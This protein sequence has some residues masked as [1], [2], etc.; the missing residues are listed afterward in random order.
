MANFKKGRKS[1]AQLKSNDSRDKMK[2]VGIKNRRDKLTHSIGFSFTSEAVYHFHHTY[3]IG[4]FKLQPIIPLLKETIFIA[5]TDGVLDAF[6]DRDDYGK[7]APFRSNFCCELTTCEED[8]KN[9][10][11]D[12]KGLTFN[13][14]ESSEKLNFITKIASAI[15]LLLRLKGMTYFTTPIELSG[16]TFQELSQKNKSVEMRTRFTQSIIDFIPNPNPDPRKL[17]DEDFVWI[18]ENHHALGTLNENG[19]MNFFHDLYDSLHFPN[20]SV[21]LTLIWSGIESIVK[22]DH[23]G[24]RHSIKSRCAMILGGTREEQ[25]DIFN[26]VGKLYNFRCDVIHGNK[27]FSMLNYMNDFEEDDGGFKPIGGAK[28]LCDSYQILTDLLLKVIDDGKFPTKSELKSMQN[29][30]AQE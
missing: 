28:K 19:R 9:L 29:Q 7:Y 22:S 30:Y 5:N 6:K 3:E 18:N 23:T 17:V 26:K 1:E 8:W 2:K 15:I 16:T 13:S 11:V 4:L 25:R 20:V 24:T 10:V 14:L 12:D 27:E 21:Q